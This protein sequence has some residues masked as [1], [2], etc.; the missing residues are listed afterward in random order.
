M[1]KV[2]VIERESVQGVTIEVLEYD[3]LN[4]SADPGISEKLYFS[5]K[6]GIRLR[7]VR[8]TLNGGEIVTEAGALHYHFGKI[9]SDNKI[10]G[11]GGIARRVLNAALNSES[12]FRPTYRGKGE[13]FLEPSFKHYT[14]IKLDNDSLILDDG[15]FYCATSGIEVSIKTVSNISSALFGS[16]GLTQTTVKGSGIVVLEIPVPVEELKE[17]ELSNDE[18]KVDGHFAIMRTGGISYS[19]TKSNKS[20]IKSWLG[21]EG[22]VETFRGTGTVWLAPTANTYQEL[23]RFGGVAPSDLMTGSNSRNNSSGNRGGNN[24][25]S[26]GPGNFRNNLNG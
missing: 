15:M 9:D 24:L 4:G 17:I 23:S 2:N 11:G 20:L 13:I 12:L 3:S 22:L 18:L 26:G 7:Q 10:S 1:T 16:D 14:V 25:G 19:V 8:I 5:Q 6:V 21:G